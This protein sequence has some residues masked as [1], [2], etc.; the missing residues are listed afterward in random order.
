MTLIAQ[1]FLILMPGQVGVSGELERKPHPLRL[2]AHRMLVVRFH[3]TSDPAYEG[4]GLSIVVR[5]LGSE[6]VTEM[7]RG[8]SP[9]GMPYS[10]SA[11][12]PTIS[13]ALPS[14]S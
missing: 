2:A 10:P 3:V 5:S 7:P 1:M 13:S 8:A 9:V 4:V 6:S 14:M 11:F 12:G